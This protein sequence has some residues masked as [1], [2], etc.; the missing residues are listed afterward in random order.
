VTLYLDTS[1]L[2]KLYVAEPGSDRVRA[3]V[4]EATLV[5]TSAVAYPET[6]AAL[7]KRR[8]EGGLTPTVFAKA[9][10][11]FERDWPK[12]LALA[13]SASLCQV[14]GDLAEQYRL[15]G[16]DSVHLASYL[17]VARRAGA[18][19]TRF[20]SDDD[21]LNRAAR[22]AARALAR[23]QTGRVS[24]R[25]GENRRSRGPEVGRQKRGTSGR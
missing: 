11:A 25:A 18:A 22:L 10:R 17:E 4:N 2:V 3:L 6:R 12:Y 13:A 23:E 15:R 19:Q 1:S 16:F 14:A 20:S 9:K 5:A 8:R 24:R 7:A 21:R